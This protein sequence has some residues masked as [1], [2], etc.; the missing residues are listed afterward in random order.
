MPYHLHGWVHSSPCQSILTHRKG[1]W[2]AI[3]K[4][5]SMYEG[6]YVNLLLWFYWAL[7]SYLGLARKLSSL[8]FNHLWSDSAAVFLPW[9]AIC[10][11]LE[12]KCQ[13]YARTTIQVEVIADQTKRRSLLRLWNVQISP[14]ST[15]VWAF[16]SSQ[17]CKHDQS[18]PARGLLYTI[19]ICPLSG[20]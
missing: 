2:N 16:I 18:S 6:R 19:Y 9:L 8:D 7:Y 3:V 5:Q 1:F 20:W 4:I 12:P 13:R 15:P 11:I 17:A 10:F 14:Y